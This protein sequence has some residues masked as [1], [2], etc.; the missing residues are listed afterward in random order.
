LI[1]A[2][3]IQINNPTFYIND[4]TGDTNPDLTV[5]SQILYG[6]LTK[7]SNGTMLLIGSNSYG[8]TTISGGTLQ[9]GN[10]GTNGTLGTGGVTDNAML[11]FN[12]SDAFVVA[13][14]ISGT[15]TMTQTGAGTLILTGTS[16]FAGNLVINSNTVVQLGTNGTTGSLG[17]PTITDYGKLFYKLSGAQTVNDVIN[18]SGSVTFTGTAN[19]T[20]TGTN[21]V[22]TGTLIDTNAI[23]SIAKGSS[24][25]SGKV[26]N[27][28][29]LN[30]TAATTLSNS[31]S[32]TGS[33]TISGSSV[34]ITG[35]NTFTGPTVVT[36]GLTLSNTTGPALYSSGGSGTIVL[37]TSGL[38][39]LLF[40]ANNQ[41]GSNVSVL[42]NP[43]GP[44]Y[45]QL[46]GHN[47][48]IGNLL[49]TNSP[50]NAVIQ[51]YQ[52]APSSNTGTTTLTFYQTTNVT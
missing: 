24:F 30:V 39:A 33:L 8:T 43:T 34:V 4:V 12:R 3:T 21:N 42:F 11:V 50:G 13:N 1:S 44:D 25:G 32:G 10:G 9:I 17:S 38:N 29:G 2:T 26:V 6:A 5:S 35:S 37:N 20:F 23:L 45:M 47:Q 51:N 15:G 22:S 36:G 7:A 31:I 52:T 18:G 28:G 41:L 19:Y 48:T 14:A 49:M 40:G 46:Q 27:N 16:T